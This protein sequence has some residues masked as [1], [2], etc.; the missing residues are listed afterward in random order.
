MYI[1]IRVFILMLCCCLLSFCCFVCLLVVVVVVYI[2]LLLQMR[3]DFV[4]NLFGVIRCV[5]YRSTIISLRKRELRPVC[6]T[7]ATLPCVSF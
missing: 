7:M 3:E 6:F 5:L 4:F 2:L 1:V